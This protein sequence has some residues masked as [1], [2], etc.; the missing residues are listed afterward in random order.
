[1]AA[2]GLVPPV[3]AALAQLHP[4]VVVTV[5]ESSTTALVR[6]VRA[7]TLDVADRRAD[8]PYRPPD[9]ESPRSR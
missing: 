3:L 4:D 5:R 8:P 6:S 1:M 2:A 9:T 7:G